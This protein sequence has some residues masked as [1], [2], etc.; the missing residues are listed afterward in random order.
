MD[1]AGIHPLRTI[2]KLTAETDIASWSAQHWVIS[3]QMLIASNI[4]HSQLISYVMFC[5]RFRMTDGFSI[6]Y[7]IK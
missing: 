4:F 1:G 6:Q 7:V 3:N 5:K 2:P